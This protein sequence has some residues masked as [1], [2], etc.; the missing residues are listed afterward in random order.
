MGGSVSAGASALW[1]YQL[2]AGRYAVGNG[3]QLDTFDIPFNLGFVSI[4]TVP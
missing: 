1:S 3:G 4:L 2:P